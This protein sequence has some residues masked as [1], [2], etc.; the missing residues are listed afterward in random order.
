[1]NF[2]E[3]SFLAFCLPACLIARQ[4]ILKTLCN[5]PIKLLT[6][7]Y[8][9]VFAHIYMFISSM[10]IIFILPYL[11]GVILSQNALFGRK[12]TALKSDPNTGTPQHFSEQLFTRH[13]PAQSNLIKLNYAP[14]PAPSLSD[15]H[16]AA[17]GGRQI[18]RPLKSTLV[19]NY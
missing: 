15:F 13:L 16:F 11:S 2:P 10:S 18:I 5:K 1:M 12:Y 7:I 8:I 3:F 19:S 9:V 6:Y 4:F 17:D 14:L